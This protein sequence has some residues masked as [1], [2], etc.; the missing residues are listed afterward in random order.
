[1]D[2]ISV[3]QEELIQLPEAESSSLVRVR[4]PAGSIATPEF[5]K[6]NALTGSRISSEVALRA[7]GM[8]RYESEGGKTEFRRTDSRTV[9]R[10][11]L[12]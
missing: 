9:G 10:S 11:P 3:G 5:G 12:G 1:M 7:V 4:A 8:A 6:G 2:L